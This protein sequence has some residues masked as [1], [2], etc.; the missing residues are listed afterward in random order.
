MW[1]SRLDLIDA[2]RVDE[3]VQLWQKEF[4][5][6]ATELRWPAFRAP[7]EIEYVGEFVDPP[8]DLAF[9]E[10]PAWSRDALQRGGDSPGGCDAIVEISVNA[11]AEALE[12]CDTMHLHADLT[13]LAV[14]PGGA[15]PADW[16]LCLEVAEH[17]PR[18]MEARFVHA[19]DAL[20][21][22]GVRRGPARSGHCSW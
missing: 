1:E 20:N 7:S 14:G 12:H 16:V 21:R 2:C 13:S 11:Y 9:P 19:L 17:I 8:A 18:A 5:A 15:E 10:I 6:S 22:R 3:F 4:S